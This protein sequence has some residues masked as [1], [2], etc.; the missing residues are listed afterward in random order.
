[1]DQSKAQVEQYKIKI[2]NSKVSHWRSVV[3]FAK[4]HDDQF[5]NINFLKK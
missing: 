3:A 4:N 5:Q 2:Q 1:M